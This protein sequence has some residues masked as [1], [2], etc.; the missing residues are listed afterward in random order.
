MI[1]PFSWLLYLTLEFCAG[2]RRLNNTRRH[3][4]ASRRYTHP[5]RPVYT[6]F[7]SVLCPLYSARSLYIVVLN[8]AAI[9]NL[10]W[11]GHS[12]FICACEQRFPT[13]IPLSHT[14]YIYMYSQLI[15]L[16][17]TK[18]VCERPL[19]SLPLAQLELYKYIGMVLHDR[20]RWAHYRSPNGRFYIYIYIFS[21]MRN[22]IQ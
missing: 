3:L 9:L 19:S 16:S 21:I 8:L 17:V 15:R 18:P 5:L 4:H 2:E 1:Y 20:T 14:Y 7:A 6:R 22:I 10:I 11:P 12:P 13:N